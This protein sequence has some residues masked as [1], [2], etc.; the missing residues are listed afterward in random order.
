MRSRILPSWLWLLMLLPVVA[1]AAEKGWFGVGFSME[2][3]GSFWNPVLS[4][5]SVSQVA[6][7]SPAEKARIAVA[8]LV[9]EIE[10]IPVA[11]AKGEQ[12]KKLRAVVERASV[13][14]DELHM[15]LRRVNGATY[16]VVLVAAPRR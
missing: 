16:S 10:G 8:D 3:A 14:G 11:G 12:L 2:V 4:S 5:V 9:L 13:P 1:A 6:P 15:Q 7:G